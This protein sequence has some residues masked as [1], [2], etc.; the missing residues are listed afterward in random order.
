MFS[1]GKEMVN[2]SEM[3]LVICFI[4]PLLNHN[5]LHIYP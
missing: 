2:W 1:G 5:V 4:K 3:K